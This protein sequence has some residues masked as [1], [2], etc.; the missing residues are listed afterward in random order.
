MKK[1]HSAATESKDT[2][3]YVHKSKPKITLDLKINE[4]PWT[5]R[6]KEFINLA[7]NKNTKM[8]ICKG[9][10]GTAKTILSVYCALQKLNQKKCSEIIYTRVPVEACKFGI[11]FIKGS[12]D[13]KMSPYIEPCVD[14]LRELLP[15]QHIT[16]LI[17]DDRVIGIPVGFLRG[18]N[19]TG[20]TILDEAQNCDLQ[21]LLL[22]MSRM[23]KYSLLMIAGDVQQQD[24]KD[25]GFNKVYNAFNNDIAKE[26][27]IHTFEF[28][29]SDIMRSDILSY[30]IETFEEIKATK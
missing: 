16:A 15:Q 11:G 12:T 6:Q 29:K 30:I 27:G 19:L 22:V 1:N 2:S 9:V 3:P 21:T 24:T 7:L 8:I 4:L 5:P 18:L 23:A 25:S 28:D 20:V 26:K 10:A 14:K 13:E 17:N